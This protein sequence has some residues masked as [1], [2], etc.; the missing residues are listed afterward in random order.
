MKDS[1]KKLSDSEENSVGENNDALSSHVSQGANDGRRKMRR[2]DR[3]ISAELVEDKFNSSGR[4]NPSTVSSSAQDL[5][6]ADGKQLKRVPSK[7]IPSTC[8]RG[9][10]ARFVIGIPEIED[11]V[12]YSPRIKN[13]I[14]FIIALAAI[15]GPM[16]YSPC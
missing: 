16:G 11:P 3:R 10:F 8:R 4:G 14:V 5:E 15:A 6:A 1:G 2:D 9:L 12:Q 13:C 7:V